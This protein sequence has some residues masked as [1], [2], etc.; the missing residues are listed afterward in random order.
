MRARPL[1]ALGDLGN[2]AF[3]IDRQRQRLPHAHVIEWLSRHI[4]P[5][6]IA[7]QVFVGMKVRTLAKEVEQFRRNDILVPD[8]IHLAGQE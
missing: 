5:E 8:D 4:E 1:A 7:A 2:Y 3:L 6:E